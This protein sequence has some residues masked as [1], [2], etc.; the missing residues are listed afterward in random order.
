MRVIESTICH[1]VSQGG[2]KWKEAISRLYHCWLCFVLECQAGIPELRAI[3]GCCLGH[4]KWKEQG[5]GRGRGN[6]T[7]LKEKVAL[8]PSSGENESGSG[9]N[10][11]DTTCIIQI[12]LRFHPFPLPQSRHHSVCSIDGN[13]GTV[14]SLSGKTWGII[15]KV[16]SYILYSDE[17]KC[18]RTFYSH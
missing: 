16:T 2:L 1:W 7:V 14:I 18:C 15:F 8:F 5:K 10:A 12:L 9:I 11:P 6:K 3:C 4:H 17:T 13:M